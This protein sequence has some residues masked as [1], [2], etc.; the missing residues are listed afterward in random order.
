MG[1]VAPDGHPAGGG[2]QAHWCDLADHHDGR[3]HHCHCGAWFRPTRWEAALHVGSDIWDFMRLQWDYLLQATV[4][5]RFGHDVVAMARD[6]HAWTS[7]QR[8]G[9]MEGTHPLIGEL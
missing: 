9:H 4:C 5:R 8:C 3:D 1:K 6:G 2:I 7:C